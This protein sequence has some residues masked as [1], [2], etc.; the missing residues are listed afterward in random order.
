MRHLS[1][2]VLFDSLAQLVEHNTFN[3]GVMGSNPMRVT[4]HNPKSLKFNNLGFFI[5]RFGHFLVI[6]FHEY[7]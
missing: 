1:P 3:V 2:K 5:S 7:H 4:L 6:S